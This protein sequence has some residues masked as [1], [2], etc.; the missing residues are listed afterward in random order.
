MNLSFPQSNWTRFLILCNCV[1]IV[2]GSVL[3]VYGIKPQN[4]LKQFHEILDGAKPL[5]F[6]IACISG[7]V[8]VLNAVIGIFG[9]WKYDRK[10]TYLHLFIMTIVTL[11][12]I[13]LATRSA[14]SEDPFF[15]STNNS[16][17]QALYSYY[18]KP[19]SRAQI[20]R[21]QSKYDCCGVVSY[22]DYDDA[23]LLKPSSSCYVNRRPR[24]K[25][26]IQVIKELIEPWISLLMYLCFIFGSVQVIY[27]IL[28]VLSFRKLDDEKCISA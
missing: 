21:L 6:L 5:C 15:K 16:L 1:F 8:V 22:K 9:L 23:M 27:L 13:G 3:I 2:F 4:V 18:G 20:D 10:I 24:E 25:G 19:V 14:S 28:S 7:G 11:M 17:Y 12:E 26:C